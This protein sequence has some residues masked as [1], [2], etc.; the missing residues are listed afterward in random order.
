MILD[1]V[2]EGKL[3]VNICDYTSNMKKEQPYE[4]KKEKK[5]WSNNFLK[6]DTESK[7]LS[8]KE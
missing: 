2:T 1:Y 5:P 8:E 6:V 3:K 4:I 7:A